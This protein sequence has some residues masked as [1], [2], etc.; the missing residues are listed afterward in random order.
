MSISTEIITSG[1]NNFL[2]TTRLSVID[3]Y[4]ALK[5]SKSVWIDLAAY[6]RSDW[7]L[8]SRKAIGK[9]RVEHSL[10]RNQEEKTQEF[11]NQA[12]AGEWG[13]GEIKQNS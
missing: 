11:P 6:S 9:Q 13:V 10:P 8:F 1:C 5:T 3:I 4:A 7:F 2:V 12:T